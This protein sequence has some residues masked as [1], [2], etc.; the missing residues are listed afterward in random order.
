MHSRGKL[1]EKSWRTAFG[2]PA[3]IDDITVFVI[4]LLPYKEEFQ[5]W[6]EAKTFMSNIC[7]QNSHSPVVDG[8][9][10]VES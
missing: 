3:T 6:Q 2:K 10:A 9:E 4:P 7:Q 1:R 5:Q 8:E